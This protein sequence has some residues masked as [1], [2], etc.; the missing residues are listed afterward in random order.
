M[1]LLT[2]PFKSHAQAA[3]PKA[4]YQTPAHSFSPVAAA[5]TVSV[6]GNN[7]MS[8]DGNA[9]TVDLKLLSLQD[10]KNNKNHRH[11]ASPRT[12]AFDLS[13]ELHE[14]S[15]F[16]SFSPPTTSS[17]KDNDCFSIGKTT[18]I[19]RPSGRR[20]TAASGRGN[21]F[22]QTRG[23][24]FNNNNKHRPIQL[25]VSPPPKKRYTVSFADAVEQ[26]LEIPN[27]DTIT[28]VEKLAAWWSR[29][30]RRAI[31]DRERGRGECLCVRQV[32]PSSPT[33]SDE[34][35]T[36]RRWFSTATMTSGQDSGNLPTNP[37][38]HYEFQLL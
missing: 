36:T 18:K 11:R 14:S 38:G 30:E 7:K 33:L 21:R 20:Y 15:S 28:D 37:M 22:E 5:A 6:T 34:D 31:K 16:S 10:D 4:V 2:S 27:R 17:S 26:V 8:V 25:F 3:R 9:V 12:V 1:T 19:T 29:A 23:N 13:P 35:T 24:S 32:S